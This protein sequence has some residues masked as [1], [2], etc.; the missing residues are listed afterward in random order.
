E[1]LECRYLNITSS[2]WIKIGLES[3]K[4]GEYTICT[5]THLSDFAT[6]IASDSEPS[7]EFNPHWLWLLLLLIP[8]IAVIG[9]LTALLIILYK[10]K[11]V[12]TTELSKQSYTENQDLGGVELLEVHSQPVSEPVNEEKT[13]QEELPDIPLNALE[14]KNDIS[15]MQ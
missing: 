2:Q 12:G 6:F 13:N 15:E 5:T 7:S 1:N 9:T 14:S 4:E 3:V 10:K 11:K 8:G